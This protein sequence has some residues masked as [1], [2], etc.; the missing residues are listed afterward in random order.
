MQRCFLPV[1]FAAVFLVNLACKPKSEIQTPPPPFVP[2]AAAPEPVG[3]PEPLPAPPEIAEDQSAVPGAL[4][5]CTQPPH[6]LPPPPRPIETTPDSPV[7]PS[8]A[9]ALSPQQ[10]RLYRRELAASV[11]RARRYLAELSSRQLTAVQQERRNRVHS[12]IDQ[13]QNLRSSDLATA[14]GLAV[15]AEIL[16]R[17]LLA[18]MP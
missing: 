16:A 6:P 14:H 3:S 9:P 18:S 10:E 8:L 4:A 15:R 13:A 12:F 5:A 7:V 11:A 1:L 17:E 2:P